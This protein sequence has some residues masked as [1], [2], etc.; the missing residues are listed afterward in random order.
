MKGAGKYSVGKS[1]RDALDSRNVPGPGTYDSKNIDYAGKVTFSKD[2][3][4]KGL[5]NPN[6]GPGHY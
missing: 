4:L 5:S 3:R 2:Q 6:P 1:G